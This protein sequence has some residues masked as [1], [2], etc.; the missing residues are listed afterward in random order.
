MRG[1][2]Q[3]LPKHLR[4][5]GRYYSL[6]LGSDRERPFEQ[7]V[8]QWLGHAHIEFDVAFITRR[9]RS[10]EDYT[11]EV[12]LRRGGTMDD[13]R[14]WRAALK[15][16]GVRQFAFGFLAIQRRAE[17]RPAFTIRRHAGPATS[18]AEHARLLAWETSLARDG[19]EPILKAR[20]RTNPQARLRTE[21]RL[22][23]EGWRPDTYEV[24][25]EHPFAAELTA[26]A[27][28]AHLLASADG[29]VTASELLEKLKAAGSV[30]PDTP[31]LEYAKFLALLVS[32]GFLE[33]E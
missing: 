33:L 13:L 21:F 6:T 29:T 23:N 16:I 19:A 11:S 28:A 30:N 32:G 12:V 31:P 15:Q 3:G 5:G 9:T 24:A 14:T 2:V 7:R 22:T 18:A 1:L 8:R 10:P 17:Q 25:I 4:P 26:Q 27:W 20:P